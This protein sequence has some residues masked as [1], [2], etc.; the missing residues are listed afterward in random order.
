[1][2][3][4]AW[5]QGVWASGRPLEVEPVSIINGPGTGHRLMTPGGGR[6]A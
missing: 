4:S 2:L 1:M 3:D 6:R 5:P